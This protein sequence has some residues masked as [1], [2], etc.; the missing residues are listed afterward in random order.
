[1]DRRFMGRSLYRLGMVTVLGVFLS[2]LDGS[3][4]SF[5][6]SLGVKE[7]SGDEEGDS[8]SL[9]VRWVSQ[10]KQ[11]VRIEAPHV[12]AQM[13]E[14][15]E[16]ARTG[17]VRFEYRVC[18]RRSSWFDQCGAVRE[19]LHTIDFENITESYRVSRDRMGDRQPAR[20]DDIP[21]RSEA[22]RTVSVVEALPLTAMVEDANDLRSLAA[23][24]L[25]V[26]VVSS[27]K[28]GITKTLA[29]ISRVITLGLVDMVEE[30]SSWWDFDLRGFRYKGDG[31]RR[32]STE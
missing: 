13:V 4:V 24:Y 25:Q 20:V 14:C 15:V 16:S 8:E 23:G 12:R 28:G 21:L 31:G 3:N 7:G 18:Q 29:H 10:S 26:R 27:C 5:A 22:L 6:Q 11:A 32:S 19:E 2:A 1:M 30:R 9:S 17:R